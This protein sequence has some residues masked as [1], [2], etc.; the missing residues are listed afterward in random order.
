[1]NLQ[2][3]NAV[4]Y[5]ASGSMG[6][7][8]AKALAKAGAKIFLTAR[9][10]AKLESLAKEIKDNGGQAEIAMVDGMKGDAIA[11]H[12]EKAFKTGGSVDIVFNAVGIDYKQGVALTGL[13]MEEYVQPVTNTLTTQF[14]TATAAARIMMKQR[15]GSIIF[16]TAT[17]GGIGYPYTGGFAATCAAIE[18]FSRNL[19]AE[20]GIYGVRVNTIRSGGSPDSRIFRSAMEQEPAVMKAALE[21]L[22]TDTMLRELPVMEDIANV[23]VFLASSASAKITGHTIDVTAGTTAAL[24]YRAIDA[25]GAPTIGK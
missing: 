11:A 25:A 23:A 3:K 24:S 5:G 12:L 14:L 16:L 21:G 19:A 20:N 22:R 10:T 9:D 4:I 1:M 13:T 18:N 8:V 2:N 6:G 17:P 7:A 15:S